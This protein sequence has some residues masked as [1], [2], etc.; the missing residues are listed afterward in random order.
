MLEENKRTIPT[1]D[2]ERRKNKL[3]SSNK[4][5]SNKL[6]FWIKHEALFLKQYQ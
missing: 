2:G 4:Q 3:L 1:K 6:P 5:R